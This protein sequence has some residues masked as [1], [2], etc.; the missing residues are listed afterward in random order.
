MAYDDPEEGISNAAID[1]VNDS[2]DYISPLQGR[3][4][5]DIAKALLYTHPD[6]DSHLEKWE[7]YQDCYSSNDIYRFLKQHLR[8]TKAMFDRRVAR[9]YYRNYTCSVVDL[10]VAYLYHSPITRQLGTADKTLKDTFEEIYR[11]ADRAGSRYV[12]FIQRVTTFAQITGHCGVLVDMPPLENT[13]ANEAER[14]AN[15]HRP[16]LAL[17][18]AHQI[19]DW[20]LD[21]DGKFEWVKLCVKPPQERHWAEPIDEHTKHFVIWTKTTWEKWKVVCDPNT[22]E[23]KE[24]Q[25]IGSGTH[26]LGV[27][28]LVIV[29]NE[30]DINHEWF[31]LSTVRDIADI[32]IAILNWSSLQDEEIY[33]RCLNVLVAERMDG[34]E[35]I[36]LSHAN[37]LEYP[38][39]SQ[40]PPSY[41]VPG[42]TPLELIMKAIEQAKDEIYRLAKLGGDTGLQKARQAASGIAYAF[43]FNTTNQSLGKKAEAAEQAELEIHRLIAKWMGK[44]FDGTISY[45]REFG[46]EDFLTDLQLLVNARTTFTSETA[47]KELEKQIATRMFARKPQEL[48]DQITDE[49]DSADAAVSLAQEA[50]MSFETQ[51]AAM[52]EGPEP[53]KPGDSSSDTDKSGD[54]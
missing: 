24:A 10:L 16:Y 22:G 39:G 17:I 1:M 21:A 42:A 19:C 54:K 6:Y 37:V 32:N 9:G 14:E 40:H 51:Q 34:Q 30:K 35:P 28:P 52:T 44:E 43:E 41:L 2:G 5:E 33:E 12:V 27:V 15:K 7:K 13:F 11:D 3:N 53:K 50:Q 36:E 8:E 26:P 45:P 4:P 47:I 48:R 20:A 18:Q 49:I 46:V 29:H 38:S 25:L 31:G 23:G